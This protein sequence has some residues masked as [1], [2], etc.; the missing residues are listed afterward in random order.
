MV[1][2]LVHF[3]QTSSRQPAAAGFASVAGPVIARVR[4]RSGTPLASEAAPAL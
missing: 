4:L 2:D 3:T 1:T